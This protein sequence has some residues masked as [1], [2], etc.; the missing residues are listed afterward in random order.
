MGRETQICGARERPFPT[1]LGDST[2]ETSPKAVIHSRGLGAVR[3]PDAKGGTCPAPP[4]PAISFIRYD[5]NVNCFDEL[6]FQ[7][8]PYLDAI[9]Y[10]S[11]S[12]LCIL[13]RPHFISTVLHFL[14]LQTIL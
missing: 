11:V 4:A 12:F 3:L 5:K 6:D 1:D 8:E 9:F 2:V 13:S 14:I 7:L 10:V